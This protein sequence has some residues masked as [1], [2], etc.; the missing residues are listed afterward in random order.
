MGKKIPM[1]Q[2]ALILLVLIALL[3]YTLVII[4]GTV[5]IPIAATAAIASLIAIK[6]GFKWSFLEKAMIN[7]ISRA[8]QAILILFVIGMVISTWIAGGIVPAM[9]YYG[10]MIIKPSIFLVASML[11]CSIVALSTGSS[12]TTAGTAGIALIGI[13][14]GL[15]LPLPIVAGS[16]ISGA[17]FG[18]KMSPLSDTTNLAPAMAGSNLFE[19]I[20]HMVFTVTPSYIIAMV[21]FA[22]LGMR[23]TNSSEVNMNEVAV[24]MNGLRDNFYISPLLL[25]PPCLIIA[26]V[27]FKVPALPGL[28]GGA[29]LGVICAAV[30]QGEN[31]GEVATVISYGGYV[32]ETGIDFVDTLLSRGGMSS[33]YG[34]VG[35]ILCAMCFGGVLDSTNMLASICDVMLKVAKSTGLLVTMVVISCI[36]VN[37]AASDQYLSIVLPG[38]MFKTAFEDRKLK[39]KNL[40]RCLEDA[41]TITSCLIPWNTCG[42]AM[43]SSLGVATVAYAP[44]CFLNLI[45][46]LVSIFYGFT[47]ITMEKM[48]DAE[49][50]EILEQRRLDNEIA[51]NALA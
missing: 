13:G 10:L 19:H 7:G 27:I 48:T 2:I 36:A 38:R 47:G 33:M 23:I 20:K 43:S 8:M 40:S 18:D 45:N 31:F 37:A 11:L 50:E 30:F 16:I 29:L 28:F 4:G 24:L 26:M 42:A 1:W 39:A 46:P 22:V 12:W 15:G 34:T 25:I 21:I 3:I 49:Y 44:Y 9:I 6:N 51:A 5:H 14:A 17:Y 32:S 35:I 41:G